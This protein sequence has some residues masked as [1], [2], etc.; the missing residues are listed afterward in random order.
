MLAVQQTNLLL[1]TEHSKSLCLPVMEHLDDDDA[2]AD[3]DIDAERYSRFLREGTGGGS[4]AVVG[5]TTDN[6]DPSLQVLVGTAPAD[7]TELEGA[8]SESLC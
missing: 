6:A 4:G 5:E 3:A 1:A 2:W 8:G 7:M